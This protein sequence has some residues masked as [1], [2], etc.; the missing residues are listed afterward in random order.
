M[1][2]ATLVLSLALVLTVGLELSAQ[3]GAPSNG[4]P[5]NIQ[6]PISPPA[7]PSAFHKH[8]LLVWSNRLIEVQRTTPNDN[9]NK[10]IHQNRLEDT[11]ALA[12]LDEDQSR[13]IIIKI[14]LSLYQASSSQ[15]DPVAAELMKEFQITFTP[16]PVSASTN[17]TPNPSTNHHMNLTHYSRD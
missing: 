8:R 5:A 4:A 3:T 16:G 7:N 1:K 12:K 15:S 14:A 2:T 6:A 17:S 13:K 9:I 10:I 11:D